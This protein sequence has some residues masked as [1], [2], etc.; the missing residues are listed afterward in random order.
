MTAITRSIAV[1]IPSVSRLE[2][3][4]VIA[5]L[6]RAG[7]FM[8]RG[9]RAANMKWDPRYMLKANMSHGC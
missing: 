7:A 4:G 5:G 1:I 8:T 2:G 3:A 9:F 6:G